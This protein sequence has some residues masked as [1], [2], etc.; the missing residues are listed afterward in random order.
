MQPTLQSLER[1]RT[2]DLG[3]SCAHEAVNDV[4][5]RGV[6]HGRI[7]PVQMEKWEGPGR[8]SETLGRAFQLEKE[9]G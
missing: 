9:G 6:R 2:V 5:S 7:G 4:T 1:S 3:T 8:V